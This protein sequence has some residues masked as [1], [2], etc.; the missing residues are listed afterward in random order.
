MSA[1]GG[2]REVSGS[3]G[4]A[5]KPARHAAA[6]KRASR[7]ADARRRAFTLLELLLASMFAGIL[8]LGLW[9]LMSTYERLFTSGETK[10][11]R[12][13][14]VRVVL[15]Q[16]ADDLQNA[17]ADN[18]ASPLAA[19][20]PLR[21][22][23]LF[24]SAEA[25][26]VDVLQVSPAEVLLTSLESEG[27]GLTGRRPPRASE[28]RTIQWR[29]QASE[30]TGRQGDRSWSG[31]MRRELDWE[32]PA[33]PATG[34]RG[35]PSME[36]ARRRVRSSGAASP[37]SYLTGRWDIDPLDPSL[38]WVPEVTAVT[39]RYYDGQAWS[40][41]WNSL[42]RKSL[43]LAVSI[44]ITLQ[45]ETSGESLD[46]DAQPDDE[47]AFVRELLGESPPETHRLLVHLPCTSLARRSEA[48]GPTGGP[49]LPAVVTRAPPVPAPRALPTFSLPGERQ[50]SASVILPDQW[51]RTGQ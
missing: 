42:A 31:L 26:Q 49:R 17:I 33:E 36:K 28:L 7:R 6:P 32:T 18:A 5:G 25:V 16:L 46:E 20:V 23:G 40:S 9:G 45:T 24:G 43:P 1:R 51:M 37:D 15:D 11:Q 21:R 19:S 39:L 3:R 8:M 41:E 22:F 12:A 4:A 44:E 27:E 30:E 14:L 10:T 34:S 38:L 35:S 47:M 2:I 48:E 13:Q 50:P 29:F